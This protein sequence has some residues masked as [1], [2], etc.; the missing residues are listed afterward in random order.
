MMNGLLLKMFYIIL[1][2][3]KHTHNYIYIF[4]YI[5]CEGLR[6]GAEAVHDY[7]CEI[8]EVMERTF[9]MTLSDQDV[10][11][12]VPLDIIKADQEFHNYICESNEQ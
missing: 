9:S 7:M 8:N 1:H 3:H 4:R 11:E 5:I 12:V 10:V 2:T 6:P